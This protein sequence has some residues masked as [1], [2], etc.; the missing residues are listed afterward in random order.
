MGS[1]PAKEAA[2]AVDPGVDG[3]SGEVT[4]KQIRSD[5]SQ[6]IRSE[7]AY[8]LKSIDATDG[9]NRLTHILGLVRLASIAPPIVE[10]SVFRVIR[11]CVGHGEG[12]R[13]ILSPI[14]R[15]SEPFRD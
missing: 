11:D 12:D 7:V 14:I 8:R 3:G 1:T 4:G 6:L 13:D 15:S 9:L 2:D 10:A 5:Y